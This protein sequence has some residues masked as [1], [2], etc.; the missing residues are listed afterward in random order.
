MRGTI[1]DARIAYP[2]VLHVE[3]RDSR[4][5]LWRLATLDAEWSPADPAQLV[6][7][8]IDDAGIDE[9][10]GELHFSL[11]DGS[12]LEIKP[13]EAEAD[14]D[15]PYWELISPEGVALEFGPGLR[16]QIS[17]ADL[18]DLPILSTRQ[19]DVLRLIARGLTSRQVAE[20]L[21]ISE[22]TV[23]SHLRTIYK[24]LGAKSRSHAIAEAQRHKLVD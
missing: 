2:D 16:W 20:A 17:G 18:L 1:I 6:G 10:S 15:P 23:K 3:V 12:Q 5:E 4:Q 11:S 7:R 13:A 8:S 21:R 22:P 14:D 9:R 19:R 24:T